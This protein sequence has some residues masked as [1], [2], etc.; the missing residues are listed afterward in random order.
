MTPSFCT[1]VSAP[2]DLKRQYSD[3]M[4][5]IGNL[6]G[7]MGVVKMADNLGKKTNKMCLTESPEILTLMALFMSTRIPSS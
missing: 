7:A 1:L 3:G 4:V 5:S 6:Y 2:S